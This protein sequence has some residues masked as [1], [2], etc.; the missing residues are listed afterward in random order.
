MKNKFLLSALSVFF[1]V[2]I[3][4]LIILYFIFPKNPSIFIST[5][6]FNKLVEAQDN[7]PKIIANVKSVLYTDKN[8]SFKFWYPETA[9]ISYNEIG[10]STR[11]S[12]TSTI[13]SNTNLNEAYVEVWI[14]NDLVLE[15]NDSLVSTKDSE[16]KMLAK[17]Q[18]PKDW[19]K[20]QGMTTISGKDFSS[21]I[22]NDAGA[23]QLYESVSYRRA[24]D[25]HCYEI[26][27]ILHSGNIGNYET[28]AVK[29]F[30]KP[31]LSGILDKMAKSFEFVENK[32]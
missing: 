25:S 22:G 17:C 31:Y 16:Q 3:F 29:D 1:A 7:A 27:E 32:K 19:E 13:F 24:Q 11:V 30:D 9:V 5:P 21:F 4:S 8:N 6:V 2:G 15:G 20:F 14:D 18:Q 26:T 23:G 28:G 10:N 12:L